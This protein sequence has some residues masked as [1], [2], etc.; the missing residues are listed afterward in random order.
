MPT[1]PPARPDRSPPPAPPAPRIVGAAGALLLATLATLAALA[2]CAPSS[3]PRPGTAPPPAPAAGPLVMISWDGAGDAAVDRLLAEGRLPHLAALARRGVAA[4]HSETSFPSKTAP[5][6]A[7]IWTGAPPAVHGI[8]A[9]RV[10]LEP[11]GPHTVLE[12][13]SGF[14]AAALRAEPLYVT[15]AR[16]GRRVVVLSATQ[17]YPPEPHLEALR[18]AGVGTDRF[19]SL[20][21]FEHRVAG[22]RT[23]DADDW[24]PAGDGWPA[25]EA[26]PGAR[27]L[28]FEVGDCGAPCRFYA[29]PFDDPADPTAGWDRL[30]VRRGSRRPERALSEIVLA[31][32]PA[33]SRDLSAW[34]PPL[35]VRRGDLEGNTFLRL[36]ELA[37][38][39][40]RLALYQR[41]VHALRGAHTPA[42]RAAY[43]RA[44]PGFHD[45]PF[46][47][48][49][50]GGFGTP[51]PLGGDGRAERR[52]LEL[53]A[54]DL[55]MAAAGT[56][57]ALAAW[58]PGALFHY[59]PMS[60]G[61]GHTWWGL[62][63]PANPLYDAAT[64]ERMWPFYARVLELQDAWLGAVVDAAGPRATVALVSDHGMAGVGRYLY[65]N[66]VLEDAGLLVRGHGG[67]PDLSRSR[68]VA[69]FPELGVRVSSTAWRD[70][71]VPAEERAEVV[72]AAAAALLAVVD[73]ATGEPVVRRVI[74]SRQAVG[75]GLPAPPVGADL[76]VD[77]APG[78][79]PREE[80]AP[81]AVGPC[82]LPWGEGHH[83]FPPE[84]RSMHAIF[85]AA[86]PGLARGVALAPVRHVDLAPTLAR[87]A[88]L[89][90]PARATGRVLRRAL[91]TDAAAPAP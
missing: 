36:F 55:E 3:A 34:S 27:E 47:F 9:N 73:P 12:G 45:N 79:Y 75:M 66:R 37:P 54:F 10:A 19:L 58:R 32:R 17:S 44:C 51:L 83:G 85:Y 82:R 40:S 23:L 35:P 68:A 24:A 31:P 84:R 78:Y 29:L 57:F 52:A 80:P 41:S 1:T 69:P 65:L 76:Y 71:I 26:G 63:D 11:G 21:G 48:Y 14:D 90:A 8:T 2:A 60:D 22:P 5:G 43:L 88:G 59:T 46:P 50:G 64:A 61:A 28:T 74:R 16:A 86:G 91:A 33:S 30:R 89:P 70:G 13:R 4:Q 7:T 77:P 6:H 62:L 87:A 49:E 81:H 38:D 39:G 42:Q 20:S 15:A 18:A 53:V 25:A 56:R 72:D 67:E